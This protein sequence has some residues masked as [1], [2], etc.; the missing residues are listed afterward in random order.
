DV[1]PPPGAPELSLTFTELNDSGVSGIATLYGDGDQTI[2]SIRVEDAGSNHPAHI[3]AGDCSKLDPYPA[4]PLENVIDGRSTSIVDASLDELLAGDYSIDLH[5][6]VNE[7]GTLVVCAP[8]QGTPTI[9]STPSDG[10]NG[11]TPEATATEE[12]PS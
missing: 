8:I 5:M 1:T 3:H 4:F 11:V 6:S 9:V 2:V 7:L 12:P 10:T